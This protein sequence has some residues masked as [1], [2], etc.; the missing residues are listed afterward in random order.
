LPRHEWDTKP[1]TISMA[2][3]ARVQAAMVFSLEPVAATLDKLTACA[4]NDGRATLAAM[5]LTMI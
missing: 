5:G 4:G 3:A 2:A 1:N